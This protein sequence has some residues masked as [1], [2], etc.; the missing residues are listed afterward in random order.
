MF[1]AS[2]PLEVFILIW[3][4]A[5]SNKIFTLFAGGVFLF[6]ILFKIAS[7]ILSAT[8]SGSPYSLNR[9]LGEIRNTVISSLLVYAI[10]IYPGIGMQVNEFYYNKPCTAFGERNEIKTPAQAVNISGVE[11][12]ASD[13][14]VARIPIAFAAIMAVSEGVNRYLIAELPCVEDIVQLD[15]NLQKLNIE[16]KDLAAEFNQFFSMCFIPA[17]EFWVN[18]LSATAPTEGHDPRRTHYEYF[19]S[20]NGTIAP[21]TKAV[22][23][24][25]DNEW[26]NS[27]TEYIGSNFF[28]QTE[29]LYK[30]CPRGLSNQCRNSVE[31]VLSHSGKDIG[32]LGDGFR[33]TATEGHPDYN[34]NPAHDEIVSTT[35]NAPVNGRPFCD[36]WWLGTG[37]IKAGEKGL[38]ARLARQAKINLAKNLTTS[39]N[40][41]HDELYGQI[42]ADLIDPRKFDDKDD[43]W[44]V[45]QLSEKEINKAL[46]DDIS[47]SNLSTVLAGSALLNVA[48]GG[49]SS[50][51]SNVTSI[52]GFFLE[53][54]IFLQLAKKGAQIVQP[55]LLFV[56]ILIWNFWFIVRGLELEAAV[57]ITLMYLSIKSWT[58]LWH[59]LN[60]ADQHVYKQVTNESTLGSLVSYLDVDRLL[61]AVISSSLFLVVPLVVSGMLVPSAPKF[62]G[63]VDAA[64]AKSGAAKISKLGG[65]KH[66]NSSKKSN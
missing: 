32:I 17:R 54:E 18:R 2:S 14:E 36:E 39:S 1:H 42:G 50:V 63:G 60:Y 27:D 6:P 46:Y 37:S 20:G 62:A 59:S 26:H 44:L 61:M 15:Q 23:D 25:A 9:V 47:D 52:I 8:G 65:P 29:G 19:R 51:I 35:T 21:K 56:V 24:L 55:W 7:T 64:V 13:N 43:D 16:D 34:L 12:T 4:W 40:S 5:V 53:V 45:M 58:W 10:C 22:P 57:Q 11:V 30:K 3:G 28:L 48:I 38:R 33:H 41:G 31:G 66:N 49:P